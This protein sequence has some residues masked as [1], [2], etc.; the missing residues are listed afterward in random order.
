MFFHLFPVKLL[1]VPSHGITESRSSQP[2]LPDKAKWYL[3]V[4]VFAC[5]IPQKCAI[6]WEAS[7]ATMIMA[8]ALKQSHVYLSPTVVDAQSSEFSILIAVCFQCRVYFCYSGSK[9]ICK[10]RS[11]LCGLFNRNSHC[12]C[13]LCKCQY[14]NLT[15]AW[16]NGIH[17]KTTI[18]GRG[19][20]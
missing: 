5:K 19:V 14:S 13:H 4:C 11:V 16:C 6:C 18:L 10:C 7:K 20:W 3:T 9:E 17:P 15:T 1:A 2:P 12:K 8:A